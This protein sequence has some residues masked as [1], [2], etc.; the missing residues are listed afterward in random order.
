MEWREI[1]DGLEK[2][3]EQSD[4]AARRI[5]RE[6]AEIVHE[7]TTPSERLLEQYSPPIAEVYK[8]FAGQ[9]GGKYHAMKLGDDKDPS[10]FDIERIEG[11]DDLEYVNVF[12]DVRILSPWGVVVEIPLHAETAANRCRQVVDNWGHFAA[13][14]Y[15]YRFQ[16]HEGGW[17]NAKGFFLP[18]KEFTQEKLARNLADFYKDAM[19]NYLKQIKE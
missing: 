3:S 5:A 9:V 10:V 14:F 18:F 2:F 4:A 12:P 11:I 16:D 8:L 19:K 13:G 15:S 1:L 6:K 7:E 17:I